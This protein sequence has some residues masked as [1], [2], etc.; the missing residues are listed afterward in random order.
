MLSTH[1]NSKLSCDPLGLCYPLCVL[2][3]GREKEG[4]QEKWGR[5]GGSQCGVRISSSTIQLTGIVYCHLTCQ[6]C[7]THHTHTTFSS[8]K[9]VEGEREE[10]SR[11]GEGGD[12]CGMPTANQTALLANILSF[13]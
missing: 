5:R 7:T 6:G 4:K 13:R 11:R 2:F 1:K 9:E 8:W 3:A 10:R 12:Q